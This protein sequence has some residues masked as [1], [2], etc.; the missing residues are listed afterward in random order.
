MVKTTD[1][2]E[3]S[4][5]EGKYAKVV[6]ISRLSVKITAYLVSISQLLCLAFLYR[7][8][9]LNKISLD[10]PSPMTLVLYVPWVRRWLMRPIRAQKCL[11]HIPDRI[12]YLRKHKCKDPTKKNANYAG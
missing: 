9:F 8:R 10:W 3:V 2:G 12:S 7:W 11:C 4:A 5:S 1:I 6:E